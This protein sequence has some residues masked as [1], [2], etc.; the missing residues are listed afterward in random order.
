MIKQRAFWAKA[1]VDAAQLKERLVLEAGELKGKVKRKLQKGVGDDASSGSGSSRAS[2]ATVDGE[3]VN[4]GAGVGAGGGGVEG[5][6]EANCAVCFE[7]PK[8]AAIVHGDDQ[9]VCCCMEC[10]TKLKQANQPCPICRKPIELILKH[11][12]S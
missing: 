1:A 8:N 5:A 9:H 10:A 2:P 7:R 11:Y 3:E 12:G 6:D 4:V